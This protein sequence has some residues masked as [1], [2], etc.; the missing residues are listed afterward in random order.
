[1]RNKLIA[2]LSIVSVYFVLD[3]GYILWKMIDQV[4]TAT[5]IEKSLL[6][7]AVSISVY[8]ITRKEESQKTSV[9]I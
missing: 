7:L 8:L 2:R 3:I 9:K 1:M 6:F 5:I 4:I